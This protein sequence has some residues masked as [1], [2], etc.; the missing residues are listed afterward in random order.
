MDDQI[1][2][3][4]G[5]D[6]YRLLSLKSN[7]PYIPKKNYVAITKFKYAGDDR[8]YLYLYFFSP[9][10]DRFAELLPETLAP[11]LITVA[12]F[13]LNIL[14]HLVLLYYQG[15]TFEGRLPTWVPIM[16]AINYFVYIFLDNADG[17]QARRTHSSSVLGM[18][19]DHGCDGYVSILVGLNLVMILQAGCYKAT[20]L[21]C[22][23]STVPF[24][25]ATL[26]S[27][28]IGGV[29]LPEINA[30]TDGCFAIMGV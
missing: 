16:V 17:K 1:D 18:L 12:G 27:Y 5:K 13:M 19:I 7:C 24:Y 8:S 4:I 26:E 15:F 6:K 28:F 14:N 10:C 23:I 21:C 30:V 2:N 29:Y 11:N 25:F 22:L 3:V 20:L 9:L